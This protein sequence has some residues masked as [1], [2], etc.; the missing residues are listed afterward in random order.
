MS[1]GTDKESFLRTVREALGRDTR[2]HETPDYAPLNLCLSTQEQTVTAIRERIEAHRSKL[3][4]RFVEMAQKGGWKVYMA[5]SPRAATEYILSV[6]QQWEATSVVRSCQPV[7]QRVP[8]DEPLR[9]AKIHVS[10]VASDSSSKR[11]SLRK[12]ITDAAVGVTGVDYAIAETG[13]CVLLPRKGISRLVS[14]LPPVH[15]A[16]VEKGQVVET[17]DDVLA[18]TQL[19]YLRNGENM[20]S[21]MNFITGPSR[22]GDIEQT[23]TVGVHG[24]KEAHCVLMP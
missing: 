18:F 1:N 3:V 5:A 7:F 15:V 13:T 12:A 24:P 2:Y 8:L 21:Y 16:L 6:S 4:E 23:I 10:L 17:I 11:E 9:E 14:L 22:S 20:G 19:D